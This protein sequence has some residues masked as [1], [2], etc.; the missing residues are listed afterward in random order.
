MYAN[1]KFVHTS[2]HTNSMNKY[3]LKLTF[4]HMTKNKKLGWGVS[5]E[6]VWGTIP[7]ESIN[8]I[9][10]NSNP[11]ASSLSPIIFYFENVAFFHAKL[12]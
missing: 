4:Y 10:N 12:R 2:V 8:N 9:N 3:N 6:V 1:C 7:P 11:G 5:E